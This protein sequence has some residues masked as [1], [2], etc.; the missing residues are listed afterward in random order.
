MRR[1]HAVSEREKAGDDR[2]EANKSP[3]KKRT[4]C[5]R[6]V[7]A[8]VGRLGKDGNGRRREAEAKSSTS[9]YAS[10]EMSILPPRRRA[11]AD[12]TREVIKVINNERPAPR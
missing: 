4:V 11:R 5:H 9:M 1:N 2:N 8:A 10:S 6:L 12:M 7:G 3:P